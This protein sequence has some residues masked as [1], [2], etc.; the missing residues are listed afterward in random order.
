MALTFELGPTSATAVELFPEYDYKK[1][2]VTNKSQHRATS[3]KQYTYIWGSWTEFEFS[4][5]YV[6]ENDA[7]NVNSWF[8][9]NTELLFFVTSN[10]NTEVN[11]VRIQGEQ[12]PFQE[13]IKPYDNLYQG[14]LFLS[15]Y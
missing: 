13:L 11:S 8:E 4:A 2:V 15:T 3:G 7:A 6:D 5:H 10:S 12:S 14:K 1:R 9:S